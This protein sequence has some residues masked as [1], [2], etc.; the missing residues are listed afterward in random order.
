[1]HLIDGRG[2][3]PPSQG[4]IQSGTD[5]TVPVATPKNGAAVATGDGEEGFH[6]VR[7]ASFPVLREA[8]EGGRMRAP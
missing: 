2:N 4:R 7:S 1:V 5:S 3:F 8:S 6:A